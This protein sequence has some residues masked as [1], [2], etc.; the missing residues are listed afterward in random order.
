MSDK[1]RFIFLIFVSWWYCLRLEATSR[2]TQKNRCPLF[3]MPSASSLIC[4]SVRFTMLP[5][6]IY[7]T[8]ASG[9][10]SNHSSQ[11]LDWWCFFACNRSRYV[12]VSSPPIKKPSK[13]GPI[14][15]IIGTCNITNK[16]PSTCVLDKMQAK[17]LM[18]LGL[19]L[20]KIKKS[21]Y[22][23]IAML[24]NLYIIFDVLFWRLLTSFAASPRQGVSARTN[25]LWE[26]GI[27]TCHLI[28]TRSS[29]GKH[30]GR[31]RDW[32]SNMVRPSG[33]GFQQF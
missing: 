9:C 13:S 26:F 8:E 20:G 7:N 32:I 15:K 5:K 16:T 23:Y 17:E 30:G 3:S 31:I 1:S 14:V 10:S 29:S 21:I 24:K 33:L 28:N 6:Q 2:N 18:C 4:V 19:L 25:A 11:V 27:H 22:C 12:R